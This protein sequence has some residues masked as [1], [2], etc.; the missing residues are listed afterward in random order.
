MVEILNENNCI[1]EDSLP[2]FIKEIRIEDYDY[3]LA[4]ERVAKYPIDKRDDSKLLLYD[5]SNI[6]Q[7]L[8][9]NLDKFIKAG[10][11][12]VFN[13][14]KVIHARILFKK[15]TGAEIEVFCLEPSYPSDYALAF[16]QR[17][18]CTWGCIVGHLK[19]WK[20]DKLIK[21][22]VYDGNVFQLSA[23]KKKVKGESVIVEF[24]W[25]APIPF[26]EVLEI[27]GRI[28][29][30]PYLNR[31]SEISDDI[32]Y[33]TVYSKIEGS[34]A[35]PTAGLHFTNEMLNQLANKHIHTTE[36][37][38]HVGA[39]T[40]KPVSKNQISDHMMH[41]EHFE[42][43]LQTLENLLSHSENI[44]AVGTTSVRTI[45]SL[46]WLGVKLILHPKTVDKEM[47][48]SQWEVYQLTKSLPSVDVLNALIEFMAL[49]KITALKASTQILIVPGYKF[50]IIKGMVTNFHQPKSTLLLLIA[51]FTNSKWKDI[52]NYALENNFRFLS[53]GDSSLLFNQNTTV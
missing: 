51:A 21:S 53:Y 4:D 42:V 40:F 37:T 15:G 22:F 5:G 49:K 34:V 24:N 36:L 39:G 38:L 46:Y 8:F 29:I 13:N 27:S 14:T 41:T 45:E 19:R 52:Y 10:S 43:S 3:E 48:I 1:S 32:N 23:E 20:T 9:R 7:T 12:L 28:P 35:A 6:S 44:I 25:N 47:H 30:P 2:E 31:N 16:Q 26:A 17:D 33:Q 50:K 11:L 18:C